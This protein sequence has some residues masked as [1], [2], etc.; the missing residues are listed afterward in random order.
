MKTAEYDFLL[1][2]E[3]IAYRPSIKRDNSRLLVLHRDGG[4]E[5]KRFRDLPCFLRA[6]DM[7]LLNKT[8]VF[9][10]RLSGIKRGGGRL[11]ILLVKETS[12]GMWDIMAKGKYTGPMLISEGLTAYISGGKIALFKDPKRLRE[13]I[14]QEGEMPLPPYI[15][16]Q[17]DDCDK[18]RYQT[19]YAEI[20]GSIAAPTAGLHFTPELLDAIAAASVLIRHVVLHVGTGTFKL[21][22]TDDIEDHIM[23]K[24]L[25]EI[26]P[27]LLSEIAEVKSRGGRIIAVGTTTTRAVEG[28]LSGKSE[29]VSSHG[30]IRGLTDI[31]IHGRYRPMAVDSVITN[32]HLPRSTPLM[33]TAVFTGRARLLQTYETAI[34]MGYRFFSYGDAMLVL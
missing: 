28:Y 2:Q 17:P 25:F 29:I 9:P 23:E 8:K 21:V 4:V 11:E 14:W 7:L 1:P 3:L 33:L 15:R 13:L 20:E 26:N 10:A 18:E 31:F 22:K 32:F 30:A 34:S 24:E 16:R 12:P 6:G 5:H 19:V 27:S